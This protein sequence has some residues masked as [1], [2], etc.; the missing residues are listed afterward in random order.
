[1]HVKAFFII[2]EIGLVTCY[3]ICAVRFSFFKA[4]Q[5]QYN[6]FNVTMDPEII[7]SC[8]YLCFQKSAFVLLIKVFRSLK[9]FFRRK[10]QKILSQQPYVV[11]PNWN[12]QNFFMFKFPSKNK[13][14]GTNSLIINNYSSSYTHQKTSF[15]SVNLSLF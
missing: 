9:N 11:H 15:F 10:Y 6:L 12:S 1:M 2:A 7:H 5:R 8:F 14:I 13:E 3:P 4:M